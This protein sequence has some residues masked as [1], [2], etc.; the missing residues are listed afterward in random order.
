MKK[1]DRLTVE[2]MQKDMISRIH[3]FVAAL[4]KQ[5]ADKQ[6]T[7]NA[8]K[9]VERQLKVLHDLMVARSQPVQD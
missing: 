2:E 7:R 5:L 4:T 3:G 9:L 8:F 6:E 1:P